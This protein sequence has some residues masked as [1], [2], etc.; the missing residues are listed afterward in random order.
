MI[1]EEAVLEALAKHLRKSVSEARP[2]MRVVLNKANV[3]LAGQRQN[4]RP[5]CMVE[6][7]LIFQQ[8]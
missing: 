2:Q 7:V 8:T 3:V 5:Q 6:C 1:G 4:V